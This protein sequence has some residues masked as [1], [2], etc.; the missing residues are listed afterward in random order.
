MAFWVYLH[1][2]QILSNVPVFNLM[3]IIIKNLDVWNLSW[4]RFEL[5]SSYVLFWQLL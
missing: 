1:K 5:A 3:D 4:T 2:M